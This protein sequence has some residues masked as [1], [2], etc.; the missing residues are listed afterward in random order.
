MVVA[1]SE[2]MAKIRLIFVSV[3]DFLSDDGTCFRKQIV[4][5]RQIVVEI[6]TLCCD[7]N[8]CV[9]FA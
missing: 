4:C 6:A 3:L 8:A 5:R 7:K 1:G 2:V 9:R